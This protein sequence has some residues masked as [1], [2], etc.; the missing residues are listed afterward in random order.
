MLAKHAML[1]SR[2]LCRQL[3]Q[4]QSVSVV[5]TKLHL[6]SRH[7]IQPRRAMSVPLKDIAMH[8]CDLFMACRRVLLS[9]LN[10]AYLSVSCHRHTFLP[11]LHRQLLKV[12]GLIIQQG[13][14][15]MLTLLCLAL[16]L[17]QACL[18]KFAPYGHLLLL[19]KQ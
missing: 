2:K 9:S 11:S 10:M 4:L 14:D 19:N 1:Q 7:L 18:S 12:P 5:S 13:L 8:I 15:W 3:K 6:K 16:C 17:S